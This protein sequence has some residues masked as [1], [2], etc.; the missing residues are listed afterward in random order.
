MRLFA[1]LLF[2]SGAVN[3]ATISTVVTCDSVT[4]QDGA[5][6]LCN[7][8]GVSA[9]AGVQA[10]GLGASA[11]VLLEDSGMASAMVSF[12]AYYVLTVTSAPSPPQFQPIFSLFAGHEG[13]SGGGE[14]AGGSL[15]GSLGQFG[16]S[17]F[18]YCGQNYT[19]SPVTFPIGVPELF[20]LT[21]AA[22]AEES[23]V[24]I[25]PVRQA[26]GSAHVNLYLFRDNPAVTYTFVEAPEPAY[27][28]PLLFAA[29]VVYLRS[30]ASTLTM[31]R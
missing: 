26:D 18:S 13:I 23:T 10:F 2:V 29:A 17:T 4:V 20:L 1:L 30:R 16:A 19:S 6:A 22:R 24:G 3:A 14:C 12:Q 15:I 5:S 28:F 7:A 21:Y 25:T 31:K 9:G 8:N 11:S 27:L